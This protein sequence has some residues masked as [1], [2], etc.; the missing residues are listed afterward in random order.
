MAVVCV[1]ANII[2]LIW[3][4]RVMSGRARFTEIRRP[5]DI[6]NI[7]DLPSMIEINTDWC[8]IYI[9][10]LCQT[11]VEFI[12]PIHAQIYTCKSWIIDTNQSIP[13]RYLLKTNS[14]EFSDFLVYV[15]WMNDW[16]S[17]SSR[18]HRN[19]RSNIMNTNWQGWWPLNIY[20][21]WPP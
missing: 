21:R 6:L 17:K 5:E 2:F 15:W 14:Y 8:M 1:S 16:T 10:W 12:L 3:A 11:V 20:S 18:L 13:Q 9:F 4:E 19:T 7:I